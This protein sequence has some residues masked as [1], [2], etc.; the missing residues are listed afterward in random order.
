MVWTRY[1]RLLRAIGV[2]L[3]SVVIAGSQAV[4]STALTGALRDHVKDGRFEI[5]TSLRGLPLGVRDGLQTLF[6]SQTLAIAEPGAAFKVTDVVVNRNLPI[7]RM[8]AHVA[9]CAAETR[10]FIPRH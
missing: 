8:A 3:W 1:T 4:G 6:G 10:R 9:D 7:R 5:V 2:G